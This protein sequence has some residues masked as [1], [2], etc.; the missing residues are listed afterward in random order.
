MKFVVAIYCDG[1]AFED[2][3]AEVARILRELSVCV[4][5]G[6]IGNALGRTHYRT[7]MDH[8]GNSVGGATYDRTGEPG[9]PPEKRTRGRLGDLGPKRIP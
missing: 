6:E 2:C 5:E 4:R 9:Y 1:D 3:N 7:L 8:N